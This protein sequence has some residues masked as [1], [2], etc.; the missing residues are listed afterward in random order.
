VATLVVSALAPD[1]ISQQAT[2]SSYQAGPVQ[3][4]RLLL[5]T[6]LPYSVF[7]YYEDINKD[8]YT[9]LVI[10]GFTPIDHPAQGARPGTI[11]LNNGNN[12]FRAA[13]GDRP[14]SEWV[15]EVLVND[16]NGDGISD[17]FMADHGWDAPPFPGFQNQLMLGTGIGFVDAS[18]RLPVLSDFSHNA[19]A[20]DINGDGRVDILVANNAL[21][22][23]GKASYFLINRGDAGFELD[24]SRLPVSLRGVNTPTTWAVEIADM[25]KD[26]KVDLLVGRVEDQ[27][28]APSRIYWN[29]GSGDFSSAQVTQLPDMG[30]FVAGGL[31]GVI[32]VQAFDLNADGLADIQLSAYDRSFKGLG[33]QFFYN[34][35]GRQFIERTDV[36]IG[37]ATQ[38]PSS[39]RET[40]YFFR[41]QDING[42]N[43]P[44]LL[45]VDNR[46]TSPQTPFFLENSAGGKWRA[47]TRAALSSDNSVL[48]RLRFQK[49]FLTGVNEFGMSELFVF[50]S[51]GARTLGMNY[52]P[53]THTPQAAVA[54]RF[55]GCSNIMRSSVAAGEFGNLNVSFKLVQSEPGIRIQILGN[56]LKQL[57]MLPEKAATFNSATGMLFVPELYVDDSVAYRG[58]QFRLVDGDQ[59]IFELVEI[60]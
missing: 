40:P 55:D 30:R 34:L 41:L 52:V 39:E 44:E 48:D 20:G 23:P 3:F 53:I 37:G 8:S 17:L 28:A 2:R 29:P 50:D 15:R 6:D 13:T 54:N 19:A 26:G 36:C 12:T 56:S 1:V 58:L 16:F 43:Y 45:L 35:G 24:R 9:D 42:D 51:N 46:D 7:V 33:T 5:P 47:I 14:Q 31:Y 32:E 21:G 4:G 57:T 60:E 22:D 49:G 11:L 59:L 27:G 25:D 18:S 10:A 38:D